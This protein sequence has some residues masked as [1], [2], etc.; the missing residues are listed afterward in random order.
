MHRTWMDR[1]LRAQRAEPQSDMTEELGGSARDS[2]IEPNGPLFLQSGLVAAPP[3]G[4][5]A[6]DRL[7]VADPQATGF[8]LREGASRDDVQSQLARLG[9]RIT[10]QHPAYWANVAAPNLASMLRGER[11]PREVAYERTPLPEHPGKVPQMSTPDPRLPGAVLEAGQLASS[12]LPFGW[13]RQAPIVAER[14]LPMAERALPT[15]RAAISSTLYNPPPIRARPFASDYPPAKYPQGVPQDAT[16]RLTQ[17]IEGRPLVAKNVVGRN[18]VGKPDVPLPPSEYDP[19]IEAI[20]G[21]PTQYR[22]A[23]QMG[24][25]LGVTTLNHQ[26]HPELVELRSDFLPG[27]RE[28]A[29]AHELGHV[30]EDAVRTIPTRGLEHE[31]KSVYNTL[32]NPKRTPDG[33]HADPREPLFTPQN[34]HYSDADA[35][36]EYMAEAIR[37]Y[38]TDPNWFKTVAPQTAARI[39]GFFNNHPQWSR[40]I[41]FNA[42]AGIAAMNGLAPGSSP[43]PNRSAPDP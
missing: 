2:L 25:D 14:V 23:A 4:H 18:E 30:V 37:A 24:D 42:L 39:R 36:R 17:D 15:S 3:S 28:M 40:V 11:N 22:S 6:P 21:Q 10:S 26:G 5:A 33:L 16:G 34:R 27:H 35:P 29:Q 38:A 20:T 13:A 1:N 43:I 8:T 7:I 41:Q 32:N 12:F 9:A 31:L 19:V